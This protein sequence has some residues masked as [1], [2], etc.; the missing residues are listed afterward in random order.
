MSL[1]TNPFDDWYLDTHGGSSEIELESDVDEC[2][3]N[4]GDLNPYFDE[5]CV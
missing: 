2:F 3:Y 1:M 4:S 5:D